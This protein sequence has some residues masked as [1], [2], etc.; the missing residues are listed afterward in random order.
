M[1]RILHVS[2]AISKNSSFQQPT[3]ASESAGTFERAAI[4]ILPERR[5]V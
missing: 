1:G 4:S 2:K 5:T 3:E